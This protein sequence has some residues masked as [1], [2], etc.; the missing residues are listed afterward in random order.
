MTDHIIGKLTPKSNDIV[1]EMRLSG[2]CGPTGFGSVLRA[3]IRRSGEA[4]ITLHYSSGSYGD[5][6]DHFWAAMLTSEQRRA[7]A[8]FLVSYEPTLFERTTFSASE[9]SE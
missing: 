4:C 7:L 5:K 6:L 3:D 8:E 2:T 1:E 9:K